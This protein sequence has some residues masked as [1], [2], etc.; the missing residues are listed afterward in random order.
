MCSSD[1]TMATQPKAQD[2]TAAALSAI[3]EALNL[4]QS[5]EPARQ[6]PSLEASKPSPAPRI[7]EPVEGDRLARRNARDDQR[8]KDKSNETAAASSATAA[9]AASLPLPSTPAAN[10]DRRSVGQLLQAFNAR[11]SSTPTTFAALASAVW[12][13]LVGFYATTLGP[14]PTLT[15][16]QM[17]MLALAAFGPV[18]FL[19]VTASMMRRTQE[20]RMTAQ[21]LTEVAMRLA[22]PESVA[23]EQVV[24]L[25]QAIRREVASMGDGIER[26]LA[27]A[28]E[29]ET[30]V[31][32]EVSTL[33][34]SYTENERR[35]RALIEIGRA[36]V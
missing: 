12:L 36:H 31:R 22:E 35:I 32:A 17:M 11:S 5:A 6:E 16:P 10:D 18:L 28:S 4:A 7:S 15:L 29:L 3:E 21:A 27:R 2:P 26:A 14:V 34:R 24:T 1:L 23:T 20:M 9:P 13:A 30:V 33:E 19:F 8:N 25:S